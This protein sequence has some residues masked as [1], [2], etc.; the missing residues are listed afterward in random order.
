VGGTDRA[1]QIGV[2]VALV[3]RLPWP[4]SASGPL[5]NLT[6]LLARRARASLSSDTPMSLRNLVVYYRV[7]CEQQKRL[8]LGLMAQLLFAKAMLVGAGVD[9]TSAWRCSDVDG[10]RLGRVPG[11]YR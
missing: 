4:R 7:S 9:R 11:A 8:G 3:G 1:E 6:V 2:V 5:L 10:R